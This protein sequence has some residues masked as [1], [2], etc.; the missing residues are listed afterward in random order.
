MHA[1]STVHGVCG[2]SPLA[3]LHA[4]RILA[5]LQVCHPV[6]VHAHEGT[7]LG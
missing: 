2:N 3:R 4:S 7:Q 1:C 5:V 6:A